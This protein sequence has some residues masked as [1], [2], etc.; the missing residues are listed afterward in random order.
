[1]ATLPRAGAARRASGR[2]GQPLRPGQG[3]LVGPVPPTPAVR[4]GLHR[5]T[6]DPLA[7]HLSLLAGGGQLGPW[8]PAWAAR[9]SPAETSS[10]AS[11]SGGPSRTCHLRLGHLQPVVL[12]GAGPVHHP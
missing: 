7:S 8:S 12:V 11:A 5:P 2:D 1:M 9:A 6:H 3:L 10:A 4:I